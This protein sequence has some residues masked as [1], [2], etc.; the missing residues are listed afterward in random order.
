MAQMVV[1]RN[2]AGIEYAVY[3]VSF[4]REAHTTY[5]GFHI[6]ANED[7]TKYEGP[8]TAA[9]D[10]EAPAPRRRRPAS[11]AGGGKAKK[12]GE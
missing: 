6:V 8:K 9:Q 4:E 1:I 12:D 5:K 2:N 10:V 3:P 11:R 7:G